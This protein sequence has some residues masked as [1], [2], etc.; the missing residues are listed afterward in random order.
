MKDTKFAIKASSKLEDFIQIF[1]DIV[2]ENLCN[3]II[4]QYFN[5]SSFKLPRTS[6]GEVKTN[7]R[8]CKILPISVEETISKNHSV[9][10]SIDDRIFQVAASII[11]KVTQ[12]FPTLLISNDTGYELLKYDTGSF[13]KQHTD[14]YPEEPRTISL[15]LIL[16]DD[17]EGGEF[18]FFDRELIYKLKKGSAIVFPSNHLYPH[19]IMPVTSGTRY[20]IITWFI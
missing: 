5:D 14:S 3:E 12:K 10:K 2:P 20:S 8:N 4:S 15:S 9:R 19:E 16:N 17:Y 1:E 18:A 11:E 7:V 13:Y 6:D